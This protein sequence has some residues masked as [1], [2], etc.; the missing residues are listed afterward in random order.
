MNASME[1]R[2]TT[3]S[4]G[5]AGPAPAEIMEITPAIAE[6]WLVKNTNN[7]PISESVVMRYARD[8][9]DGAWLLSGESIKFTDDDRLLDGQHR[10]LAVV[11]SGVT[12]QSYV[13]RGVTPAAFVTMDS[14]HKRRA[15]DALAMLG[16]PCAKDLAA[17]ATML[18]RYATIGT[19][20]Y[21]GNQGHPSPTQIVQY[22]ETHPG[23]VESVK[24]T[25]N[26]NYRIP[27]LRGSVHGSLHYL[28]TLVDP[29]DCEA[30]F[31]AIK[32]GAN[33]HERSPLFHL[34]NRLT[35]NAID[36]RKLPV[37]DVA[38]LTIKAWNAWR[39]GRDLQMLVWRPGGAAPEKF[40]EIR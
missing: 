15:S 36:S 27:G 26:G 25:S 32:S 31:R 29:D 14:G 20:G 13:I 28:F 39:E 6:S 10:L 24:T 7:R 37:V 23:I 35:A 1:T 19:F 5:I 38:A 40:P 33:L 4:N 22:V 21:R 8:M 11:R 9:T 16:Y 2:T 30:F 17:T 3:T 12:I 18:L 34:R